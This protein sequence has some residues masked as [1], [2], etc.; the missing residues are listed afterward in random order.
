MDVSLKTAA[1]VEPVTKAQAKAHL[2]LE[3]GFTTDDELLDRLI[4]AAR[5]H[6]EM[7]TG[8]A[9]VESTWERKLDKFPSV[10]PHNP[11]AAI[12]LGRHPV[13]LVGSVKYTDTDGNEQTL[14]A[15]TDFEVVIEGT[16]AT[17]KVAPA[18]GASWPT[19]RDV[20]QA[21]V[22]EF[23]AGWA[24]VESASTTPEDLQSWVLLKVGT[25]YE[26]REAMVLGAVIAR[27]PRDFTDGLLDAFTS[28]RF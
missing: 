2:R 14:V 3:T 12:E 25:M 16:L 1:T 6:G 19:C 17:G 9:F 28:W 21:V 24:V 23:T 13:L 10:T 26:N 20:P 4:G 18:Y 27:V 15:G 8:A 22:V 7:K 11:R 5:R